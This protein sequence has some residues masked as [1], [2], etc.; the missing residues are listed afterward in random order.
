MRGSAKTQERPLETR[1]QELPDHLTS[2]SMGSGQARQHRVG[3]KRA[4]FDETHAAVQ[5][6]PC[7]LVLLMP[8]CE[9]GNHKAGIGGVH[10][11][12]R[13]MT[14]YVSSC[15][16][17][18]SSVKISISGTCVQIRSVSTIDSAPRLLE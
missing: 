2:G 4:V 10:L 12:T 13:S 15:S 14:S 8:G 6:A 16:R 11:R 7:G 5:P 18:V 3:F 1:L 17:P 9:G